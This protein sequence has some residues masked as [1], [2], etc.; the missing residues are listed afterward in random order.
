MKYVIRFFAGITGRSA[1][2]FV[3]VVL[4]SVPR[5][6]GIV[7][8]TKEVSFSTGESYLERATLVNPAISAF[9]RGTDA[10]SE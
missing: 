5:E 9:L 4:L 3:I 6:R 7:P 2:F 1:P 10:V 8:V